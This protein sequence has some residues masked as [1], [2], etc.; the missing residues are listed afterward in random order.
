[1]IH[2]FTITFTYTFKYL[3]LIVS[4]TLSFL[5]VVNFV[6]VHLV[7]DFVKRNCNTFTDNIV[8]FLFK[9]SFNKNSFHCV[10]YL[11]I[12]AGSNKKQLIRGVLETLQDPFR[13]IWKFLLKLRRGIW[14]F[15]K[16][17]PIYDHTVGYHWGKQFEIIPPLYQE[18]FFNGII[19]NW[20]YV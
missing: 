11:I 13:G 20:T 6:Y 10:N 9:K 8:F 18:K 17:L 1:M 12:W 19:K 4:K 3:L 2:W 7:Y 16:F 14:I 15:L 5:I